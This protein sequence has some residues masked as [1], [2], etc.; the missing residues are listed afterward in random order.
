MVIPFADEIR[1]GVRAAIASVAKD[2]PGTS[3][4][5]IMT[6]VTASLADQLASWYCHA[7]DIKLEKA[8]CGRMVKAA[9]ASQS[10]VLKER[11][12]TPPPGKEKRKCRPTK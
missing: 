6:A 1:S 9:L 4:K 8:T 2:H 3:R 5:D 10:Q 7:A 11:L 12:I